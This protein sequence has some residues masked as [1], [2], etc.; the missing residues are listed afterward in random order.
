MGHAVTTTYDGADRPIAVTDPLSHVTAKNYDAAGI[1]RNLLEQLD[2]IARCPG[3][4]EEAV[5]TVE[6]KEGS[7]RLRHGASEA[8]DGDEEQT[9]G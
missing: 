3:T 9:H 4:A 8:D 7:I 2:G 6:L 5:C 1:L